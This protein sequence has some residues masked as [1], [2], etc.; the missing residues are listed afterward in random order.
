[1][2]MSHELSLASKVSR[3]NCP[4]CWNSPPGFCF[5]NYEFCGKAKATSLGFSAE[6]RGKLN[7][8]AHGKSVTWNKAVKPE[9][10]SEARVIH[11]GEFK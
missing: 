4:G 1:M 2:S 6:R 3:A 10:Q 5:E 9:M 7:E 8:E 11:K